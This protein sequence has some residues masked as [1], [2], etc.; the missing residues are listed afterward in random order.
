MTRNN[1]LSI[2][3]FALT[4]LLGGLGGV[5]AALGVPTV[6]YVMTPLALVTLVVGSLFL[7]RTLVARKAATAS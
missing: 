5:F 4:G 7:G 6:M 1:L 3:C 2:I